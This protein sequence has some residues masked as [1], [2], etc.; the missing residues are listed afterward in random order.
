MTRSDPRANLPAAMITSI[1]LAQ[2]RGIAAGELA[3]LSEI[4]VLVGVNSAGKSTILDALLLAGSSAPGD[5]L[6]R[7]VRRRSETQA[8]AQ[9]LGYRGWR[10]PTVPVQT[11]I[12]RHDGSERRATCR[13][14][15]DVSPALEQQLL[16]RRS[17]A[18][19]REISTLIEDGRGSLRASTAFGSD[20]LYRFTHHDRSTLAPAPAVWLIEPQP[21]GLHSPLS[22]VYTRAAKDG[23]ER[24]QQVKAW[25]AE[26]VPG[27]KDIENLTEPGNVNVVH[28]IFQDHSVPV[29]VAGDGIQALIRIALEL[30]VSP[31]DTALVEEPEAHQHPH[32]L[33]YTAQAIVAAQ[34]RGIQVIL[35]TQSLEF[36]DQ[37]LLSLND[38]ELP[39]LSVFALRLE[40]GNLHSVRYSGAEARS[41]RDT[42]GKDFR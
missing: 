41:L 17:S 35:S 27:L 22:V 6:G 4:T 24:L 13:L 21:G 40:Q 12:V 38:D 1:R 19:Y 11:S 25:A 10:D 33:Y 3:G 42:F 29:G 31:G 16:E 30:A 39:R 23:L 36:I 32:A 5:A 28:L 26:L 34:R 18:P 37:L 8:G 7:I 14:E 2:F 9:W 15:S 20:N